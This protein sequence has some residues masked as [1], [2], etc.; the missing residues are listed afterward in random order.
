MAIF[1]TKTWV[2]PFAKIS[3]LRLFKL[4]AFIAQKGVFSF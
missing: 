4:L 3:I 1:W 2:N